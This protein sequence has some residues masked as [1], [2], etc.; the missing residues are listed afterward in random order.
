MAGAK[1]ALLLREL[2]QVLPLLDPARREL[3]TL[4]SPHPHI[5]RNVQNED[6]LQKEISELQRDNAEFLDALQTKADEYCMLDK[7]KK[8]SKANYSKK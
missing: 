2:E 5:E 7:K 6:R 4:C 8:G 1:T 3:A